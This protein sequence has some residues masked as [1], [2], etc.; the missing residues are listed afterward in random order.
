MLRTIYGEKRVK[1]NKQTNSSM[2]K[3]TFL[4]FSLAALLDSEQRGEGGGS[5]RPRRHTLGS[6]V[7]LPRG[8]YTCNRAP[9]ARHEKPVE[10]QFYT[11]LPM[12]AAGVCFVENMFAGTTIIE[13]FVYFS[14]SQSR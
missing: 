5:W 12:H 3:E 13:G 10:Q 1:T 9:N 2:V 6:A 8:G 4:K 7:V 14:R 11:V